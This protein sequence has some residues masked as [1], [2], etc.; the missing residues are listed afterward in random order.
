MLE[1]ETLIQKFKSYLLIE[2][3]TPINVVMATYIANHFDSDPLWLFVIAP[4]SSAKTEIIRSLSTLSDVYTL[5]DFTEKT[6]V[7]GWDYGKASL[8]LKLDQKIITAKDF[9]TV[10]SMRREKRAEILAQ[11][12]EIYDGSYSKVFGT[13]ANVNWKG[14]LGF[15]AGV[16]PAI[17]HHYAIFQSLGERFVQIRMSP[18]NDTQMAKTAIKNCNG[19]TKF[20]KELADLMRIC[21]EEFIKATSNPPSIPPEIEDKLASLAAFCVKARTHIVRNHYSRDLE[22]IPEPEAPARFVKQL[23]LLAKGL[24][25]IRSANEVNLSDFK[26]VTRVAFDCLPVVRYRMLKHYF[27][28]RYATVDDIANDLRISKTSIKRILEDLIALDLMNSET[29]LTNITREHLNNILL[30]QCS[31]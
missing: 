19:E 22:Y 12:R 3:L 31:E 23:C 1:Y 30:P 7:S 28:R 27:D 5:S 8:L 26:I 9:T 14:K 2:D 17:D 10:I 16:T 11:L 18:V 20:R 25:V 13:G 15:I 21:C 4:P 24:A 6:L 29:Q